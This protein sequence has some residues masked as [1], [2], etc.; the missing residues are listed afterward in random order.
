MTTPLAQAQTMISCG[1]RRAA[2]RLLLVDSSAEA[3]AMLGDLPPDG[4]H[5]AVLAERLRF[6]PPETWHGWRRGDGPVAV[7]LWPVH[8]AQPAG[9]HHAR[10]HHPGVTK[11]LDWGSEWR[12]FAWIMGETLA[13]TLRRGWNAENGPAM[14]SAMEEAIDALHAA[15][16]AHGDLKPANVVISAHGPVL[17]DWGEDTAGTPGWRPEHT[18]DAMA[19]DRHALARLTAELLTS[20]PPATNRP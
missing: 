14:L 1:R 18:H 3:D 19:R 13:Q 11:L 6:G 16:L 10:F 17:I 15:G 7:K 20:A 2:A 4:P 12:V 9:Q 8:H 5:G